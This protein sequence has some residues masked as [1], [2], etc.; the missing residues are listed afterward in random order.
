MFGQKQNSKV[1]LFILWTVV[2]KKK[3]H[4]MN[5]FYFNFFLGLIS[6]FL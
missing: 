1:N 6:T 3:Y 4:F 2:L 5:V